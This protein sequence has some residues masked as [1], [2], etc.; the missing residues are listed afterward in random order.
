MIPIILE[1][2]TGAGRVWLVSPTG[3]SEN[4]GIAGQYPVNIATS[5]LNTIAGVLSYATSGD[6]I[7]LW[8]GTYAEAV[9]LSLF[10]DVTIV[11]AIPHAAK[12]VKAEADALIKLGDRCRLI[13]IDISNTTDKATTTSGQGKAISAVGKTGVV[14]E[15][16]NISGSIG[17]HLEGATTARIL[18][19][20]IDAAE[21][22]IN[23][24]DDNGT[25]APHPAGSVYVD[26]CNIKT[27]LYTGCGTAGIG[28]FS[29]RAMVKN[30]MILATQNDIG[31]TNEIHGVAV[32]AYTENVISAIA[33][34][35]NCQIL[36]AVT[37]TVT[38]TYPERGISLGFTGGG[39]N[40]TYASFINCDIRCAGNGG[41]YYDI[42]VMDGCKCDLHNTRFN[43]LKVRGT[44][45][46]PDKTI[47]DTY[48]KP[49][50]GRY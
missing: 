11:S 36:T 17:V 50:G 44:I 23:A 25:P 13:G 19:C 42:D 8:P 2:S 21:F 24:L 12:I 38:G 5:A 34:F 7:I 15:D 1:N 10:T 22:G 6:M 39:L 32:A 43:P 14:I 26:G 29:Y 46:G 27:S 9:D 40:N 18:G 33:S 28:V 35:I 30:T 41:D 37:G 3:S 16:C 31:S 20:D 49:R 47:Q 4:F 45:T 48:S